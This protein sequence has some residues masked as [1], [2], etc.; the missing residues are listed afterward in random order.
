MKRIILFLLLL[1]TIQAQDY[2][3]EAFQQT[4]KLGYAVDLDGST[5]YASITNPANVYE[6]K[7]SLK[8]SFESDV[9]GQAPQGWTVSSGAYQVKST[10]PSPFGGS[11]YLECTTAGVISIPNNQVVGKFRFS[12]YKG[13]DNNTL[14]V[15]FIQSAIAD[16]LVSGSAYY[17]GLNQLEKIVLGKNGTDL[18]RTNDAGGYV[19]NN[20]WYELELENL[21]NGQKTLK[22]RGGSFGSEYVLVSTTGGSGTNP[23]TDNTYTS[24]NYFVLDLDP[25]DRIANIQC[26]YASGA[27]D[28]NGWE[29]ILHS[30]NRDF[31]GT[32]TDWTGSGNHSVALSTT[33]KHSG[34][35]ALAVT[36][37]IGNA[38]NSISLQSD[39]SLPLEPNK[40]YTL[41]LWIKPGIASTTI[42][43][44]IDGKT[45]TFT[46][47][48]ATAWTKCVFNFQASGTNSEIKL[49]ANQSDVVYVDDVSMTQHYPTAWN[50]WFK[51]TATGSNIVLLSKN[52]GINTS[53]SQGFAIRKS[54]TDVVNLLIYDQSGNAYSISSGGVNCADGKWHLATIVL[55]A[56]LPDGQCKVYVDGVFIAQGSAPVGNTNNQ[57]SLTIGKYAYTTAGYW[58]ENIGELQFTRFDNISLSNFDA[59]RYFKS[60]I[61]SG[62]QGGTVT[63]RLKWKG[64]NTTDFLK[65]WSSFNYNI[66]GVNL[67]YPADAVRGT[68]PYYTR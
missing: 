4:K 27:F 40:K 57:S 54:A 15:A 59:T 23:V 61:P 55:D 46:G 58:I 12:V 43:L 29:R 24:S 31:E 11:K 3:W 38:D 19:Q 16:P 64:Q 21:S 65:D 39:K 10:D 32:T 42:T 53:T 26:E 34:L 17:V 45:K 5:E 22:I 25:G 52:N 51:T 66:S 41:E 60:G 6:S 28:L 48:S 8:T 33:D 47:L 30:N 20:I 63:L 68:A 67:T 49:W 13:G 18:F 44:L 2:R 35:K 50:I 1:T 62:Y 36:T 14:K 37:G 9:V 7:Y 56:S